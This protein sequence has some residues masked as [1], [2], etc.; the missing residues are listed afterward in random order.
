M[1]IKKFF[2]RVSLTILALVL[3]LFVTG[4]KHIFKAVAN[5][6]LI[7]NTGPDIDE[8]DIFA[9]RK[10]QASNPVPWFDKT[11]DLD[12]QFDEKAK[13]Y[14]DSLKTVAYMV[15]QNDA[16]VFEEYQAGYT[17]DKVSNSFSMGKSII[18]VLVGIA[19][20]EGLIDDINDP[21][22]KYLPEYTEGKNAELRIV[23]LL[24][25]SSGINFDESYNNPFGFTAKAYYGTDLPGLVANYEVTEEPGKHFKYRSGNTQILAFLLEKVTKTSVSEYA[26]QKLWSQIGTESTAYWVLDE[27]DGHEKAFTGVYATARDFAKVGRLYMNAGRFNN[28]QIVSPEYVFESIKPARLISENGEVNTEYGYSWWTMR[29]KNQKVFY[30]RG[31]FGQYVICIPSKNTIVVRLGRIRDQKSDNKHPDDVY[32]YIDQALKIIKS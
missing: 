20:N 30:M 21:V 19:L 6:Y 10:I 5:T 15:I 24:T 28:R 9:S 16:I 17:A 22:S 32:F 23:H 7:G 27:E 3:A 11:S 1:K 4:N 2:I 8:L 26:Q 18:G 12:F 13:A 31:I 25:M 29:Y 14:M